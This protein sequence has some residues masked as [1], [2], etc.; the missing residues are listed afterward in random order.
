MVEKQNEPKLKLASDNLTRNYV[1]SSTSSKTP[2]QRRGSD[3]GQG[4][5]APLACQEAV[6]QLDGVQEGSEEED[7]EEEEEVRISPRS[8][9]PRGEVQRPVK[10]YAIKVKKQTA[11]VLKFFPF[12]YSLSSPFHPFPISCSLSHGRV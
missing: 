2:A 11:I 10:D 3:G 12:S 4:P 9:S 8:D 1:I 5:L 6:D 7:S